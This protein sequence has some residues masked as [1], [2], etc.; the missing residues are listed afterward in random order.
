[1]QLTFSRNR[2]N[3]IALIWVLNQLIH[4]MPKSQLAVSLTVEGEGAAQELLAAYGRGIKHF[5]GSNLGKAELSFRQLPYIVLIGAKLSNI[6]FWATNLTG[7]DFRYTD[8]RGADL[9]SANLTGADLTGANLS[10]ADLLGTNLT[11]AILK[12]SCLCD[13]NL[14][15][16]ILSDTNFM[17]ANLQGVII[18]NAH[19]NP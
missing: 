15:G 17:G 2:K 8:L 14:S 11:R 18:N 16:A 3:H 7:A 5:P 13:S 1:M 12:D 4:L 10:N 9:T 6:D 19:F